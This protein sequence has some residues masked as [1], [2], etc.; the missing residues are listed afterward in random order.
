MTLS[1]GGQPR[2]NCEY[3]GEMIGDKPYGVGTAEIGTESK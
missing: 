2:L 3:H 1:Y